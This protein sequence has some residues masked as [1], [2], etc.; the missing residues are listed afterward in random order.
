MYAI[1]RPDTSVKEQRGFAE[2][3]YS[4]ELEHERDPDDGNY[5][6]RDFII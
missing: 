6:C 2:F 5:P 3:L 4:E 1:D